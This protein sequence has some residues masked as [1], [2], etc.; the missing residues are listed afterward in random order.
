MLS[1]LET[2]LLPNPF[3]E[4]KHKRQ[5]RCSM[6]HQ[7]LEDKSFIGSSATYYTNQYGEVETL[8]REKLC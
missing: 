6:K 8:Y 7:C 4:K 1:V 5:T 3:N 2:D